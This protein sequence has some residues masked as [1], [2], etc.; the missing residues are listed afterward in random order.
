MNIP[1]NSF[2]LSAFL[3]VAREGSFTAAARILNLSQPAISHSIKLLESDLECRLFEREGKS[4]RLT[5]AGEQ[6]E[7]T[8]KRIFNDMDTARSEIKNLGLWGVGRLRLTSPITIC[9]HLLPSVFREFKESFPRCKID[10]RTSDTH[11]AIDDVINQDV[12]LAI[13]LRPQDDLGLIFK[14]LFSDEL[15]FVVD[16]LHPWA[17]LKQ[18]PLSDVKMQNLI[19]YTKNSSTFKM[20]EHYFSGLGVSL[21]L[22]IDMGSMEAI[23][24]MVKIGLGIGIMPAWVARDE[25]D[26]GS[27]VGISFGS[28]KLR[29]QWGIIHRRTHSLSLAEE[30][31][32]GLCRTAAE[33]F[34]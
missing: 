22:A 18:A 10:I 13:T 19:I 28:K 30:T 3:A 31:F 7:V 6:L 34:H 16:P 15:I 20:I 14:A 1:L 29:R 11:Q 8:A 33:E 17:K 12:N 21:R 4:V 24:E 5:Q 9:Q 27:L 26:E 25:I 2:H 23:K 32:V